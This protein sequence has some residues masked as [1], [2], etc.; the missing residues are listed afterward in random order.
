MEF[1]IEKYTSSRGKRESAEG[2]EQP[3]PKVLERLEKKNYK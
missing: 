2:M 3:N 1:C